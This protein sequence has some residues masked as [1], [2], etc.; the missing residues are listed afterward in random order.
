M[1]DEEAV[2]DG[3]EGGGESQVAET[4]VDAG[5]A[6]AAP[7]WTKDDT[8][9][10]PALAARFGSG[11]KSIA[12][13]AKKFSSSSSE[14]Q[15]YRQ[16]HEKTQRELEI[17]RAVKRNLPAPRAEK[18]NS[19]FGYPSK[20][21]YLAAVE[22]DPMGAWNNNFKH[23]MKN[24]PDIFKELVTPL[25]QES[26]APLHEQ[27][28]M[29]QEQKMLND[30]YS[31]HP[32][33]AANGEYRHILDKWADEGGKE[34][35]ATVAKALRG[36]GI[37]PYEFV[38]KGVAYDLMKQQVA[39]NKAGQAKKQTASVTANNGVGVK[40]KQVAVTK[41]EEVDELIA[42]EEK[43]NGKPMSQLTK[44]VMKQVWAKPDRTKRASRR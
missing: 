41:D 14:A 29:A 37:N 17:E 25:I 23:L 8:E 39:S 12:D 3:G 24:N 9:L 28:Q 35:L 42:A 32:E 27:S 30:T 38:A 31:K 13:L 22:A 6:P 5:Q 4:P 21:A 44:D 11:V 19:I 15:R 36:T 7:D 26:I 43:E 20:E 1:G 10:P 2:V 40:G 34:V 18:D 33:F 16:E